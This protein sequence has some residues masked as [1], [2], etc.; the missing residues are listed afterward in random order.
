[1]RSTGGI[2]W[3][4]M[5]RGVEQCNFLCG[6]WPHSRPQRH[7]VVEDNDG[8]CLHV[9]EGFPVYEPGKDKGSGLCTWF[10]LG[11]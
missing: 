11:V 6:I 3:T 10:H 8:G 5:G 2:A 1:M 9:R 4:E 7:L